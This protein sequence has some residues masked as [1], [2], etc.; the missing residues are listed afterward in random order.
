MWSSGVK[1][2]GPPQASSKLHIPV[3]QSHVIHV[4]TYRAGPAGTRVQT[5]AMNSSC[6]LRQRVVDTDYGDWSAPLGFSSADWT[7]PLH[8]TCLLMTDDPSI[9]SRVTGSSW[10]THTN[11]YQHYTLSTRFG[12]KVLG[13]KLSV[14][15][16]L[17]SSVA[18]SAYYKQHLTRFFL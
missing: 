13:T 8:N 17:S 12:A 3:L 10:K 7:L 16:F 9:P 2:G 6:P 5:S 15:H 18:T 14:G 1:Y 4:C 11:I